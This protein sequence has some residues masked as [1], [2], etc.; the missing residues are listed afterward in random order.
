MYTRI[1]M[2]SKS[3]LA[4]IVF[5]LLHNIASAQSDQIPLGNEQYQLLDRLDIRLGNDSILG[6]STVKPY[7]RARITARVLHIDSLAR[8]GA[9]SFQ[10]TGTDQYNIRQLLK[11]NLLWAGTYQDSCYS[12]KP[13]LRHFYTT[14]AHFFLVNVPDF[15]LTIDPLLDLQ[16]GH[17]N[18]A[19]PGY[20]YVN[21]RGV[22]VRGSIANKV[23]FYTILTDNQERAPDY[24]RN[25]IRT[26]NAVPGA[27]F[28]KHFNAGGY[29]YFDA[30]G[31]ITFSAL[32]YFHF[33]FAYDKLFIGNGYRSLL[34]SDFS[35]NYLFLRMDTRI[36]KFD[37]QHI[38]AQV[39]APFQNDPLRQM[40]PQ[41]Y[42]MLHHLSI[43]VNRWLNIGLYEN[44]MEEGKYGLQLSYLNPLIFYRSIEQ[45]L[46][47]AGKVNIGF[48]FKANVL[49]TLQ[50]YGQLLINE[51]VTEEVLHYSRGD[52]RNKQGAQLGAKYINAFHVNNLDL[53]LEGNWVRPYT[54]TNFD[55]VT[56]FTHYNQPLAHPL[57]AN[58]K[59]VIGIVKYQPLHRL[60]LTGKVFYNNQGLDSA[61][62]NFG[63][64]IF[65][66]YNQRPRDKGFSIGT[67]IPATILMA[68]TTASWEIFSNAFIE[69]SGS[70]RTYHIRDQPQSATFFYTIGFRMNMQ[71]REFNF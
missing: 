46:G 18:D 29:D 25:F 45:Q 12:R 51:F 2:F 16:I 35:S 58:F 14:P 24:V 44:V 43:Q 22:A 66:S 69:A 28:Y 21:T 40:R 4:I 56:N 30:R 62:L 71:R 61:G 49:R 7:D 59:E 11:D 19:T 13:L 63:S 6:F 39:I 1:I 38:I 70:Y 41:N 54:Y 48:D 15:K 64:N 65:R 36:W 9:L 57:G 27:G 53:Q 32:K 50:L 17:A 34:L 60:R 3:C 47:A 33:Q 10:L 52:W 67:G 20:T 8:K 68:T 26:H 37:Y 23:G 55:S 42:M 5:L 31:G